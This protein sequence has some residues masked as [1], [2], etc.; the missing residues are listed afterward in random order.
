[1]VRKPRPTQTWRNSRTRRRTAHSGDYL[2]TNTPRNRS[3][4]IRPDSIEPRPRT[5]QRQA[6]TEH[7]N[8][9]AARD[10]TASIHNRATIVRSFGR[11]GAALAWLRAFNQPV[12]QAWELREEQ[13]ANEA[14]NEM[15]LLLNDK[16]EELGFEAEEISFADELKTMAVFNTDK[17]DDDRLKTY[18][19]E[20]VPSTLKS[21]LEAYRSIA[22]PPSQL[23]AREA[24]FRASQRKLIGLPC[25]ASLATWT[26]CRGFP[27]M[28]SWPSICSAVL[29]SEISFRNTLRGCR[30]TSSAS[31]ARSQTT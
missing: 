15:D 27:R 8:R 18:I 13:E 14:A 16:I 17:E 12:S 31:S 11:S 2:A 20:R 1:M 26:D 7:L 29:T 22:P 4:T 21:D 5:G 3:N 25:F 9:V 23:A 24:Q 6:P 10:S 19:L 30:P 28:L